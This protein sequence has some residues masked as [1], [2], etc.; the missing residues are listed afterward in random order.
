MSVYSYENHGEAMQFL[1]AVTQYQAC[2]QRPSPICDLLDNTPREGWSQLRGFINSDP[3]TSQ[4][5]PWVTDFKWE[6]E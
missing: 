2:Q 3:R 4:N 6:G 1:G 5:L